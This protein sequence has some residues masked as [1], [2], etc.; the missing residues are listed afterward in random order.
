MKQMSFEFMLENNPL[1]GYVRDVME[2]KPLRAATSIGRIP[3]ALHIA[4]G[5]GD[6]T[7]LILKHF[8]PEKLSAVDRDGELIALAR[9]NH[10]SDSV[11]FSAQD[12]CS[13]GFE[14][15]SFDAAFVLAD[16]H[17]TPNWKCGVRELQRVLRP[18]GL[19]IL[20]EL[21]QETF[22][23]A[24]GRLFRA[25]ADHAYDSMLT[26]NGFRDF[27]FQSG[28]DILHFKEKVPFGLL[29]YFIMVA[30]KT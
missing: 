3:H 11:D 21:A 30:R 22:A 16:L 13:L 23:Y 28:F 12:V 10:G 6:S 15:N 25:L 18:G 5:N 4:C 26:V 20:E 14:D 29:K 7:Q 1:R 19:L 2:V 8:S 27:V 17:N 24:A 9:K